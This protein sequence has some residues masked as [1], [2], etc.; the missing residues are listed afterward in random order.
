MRISYAGKVTGVIILLGVWY[1][2][3]LYYSDL[4]LP[5]PLETLQR[6]YDIFL[7]EDGVEQSG[8]TVTRALTGFVLALSGAMIVGIIAGIIP[9]IRYIL[10][11]VERLMVSV[12]PIVWVVLTILW[13][14]GA[15]IGSA[16]VT[17]FISSFPLVY[18]SVIQG[19]KTLD[20]RLLDMGHSFGMSHIKA[21]LRIGFVHVLSMT[22][23][24][25]TVVFG[26]SWKVAVM[27]EVLGATNGIGAQISAARANLET[28]DVFA[29]I[30]VVIALFI[31]TDAL[32]IAP[33]N[34]Y[35][36]KWR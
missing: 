28:R 24:A 25:I 17:I 30:I 20:T 23:P 5:S 14:G 19:V 16:V 26:Q 13:F 32:F 7:F 6:L 2:V 29:W 33:M 12:P 10:V 9:L 36:M 21:V 11:P 18:C 35:T 3:S 8:I 34:K 1:W 4:I 31:T 22:F 27:A 15:G